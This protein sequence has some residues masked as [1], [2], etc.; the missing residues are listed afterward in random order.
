[1]LHRV[2]VRV[3][4]EHGARLP[5]H[6]EESSWSTRVSGETS[7]PVPRTATAVYL[8]FPRGDGALCT[9]SGPKTAFV[10]QELFCGGGRF[11]VR[12]VSSC[13]LL[14]LASA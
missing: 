4:L 1:M 5:A 7:P 10:P 12:L 14:L 3:A 9:A 11:L 13:P 6:G 2:A 8:G